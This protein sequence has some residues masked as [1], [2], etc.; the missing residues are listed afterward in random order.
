MKNF[1]ILAL[2]V[3]LSLGLMACSNEDA[4]SDKTESEVIEASE[5]VE[6]SED[7][8]KAEVTEEAE[9][10]EKPSGEETDKEEAEE[11]TGD[12]SEEALNEFEN[13]DMGIEA[14]EAVDRPKLLIF[15]NKGCR[16]CVEMKPYLEALN[17]KYEGQAIIKYIDT[18]ENPGMAGKYPIYGTPAMIIEDKEGKA[19]IPSEDFKDKAYQFA[20]EG[21]SEPSL[22]M[23]YGYM[24]EEEV[25]KL[26]QE[27]L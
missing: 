22:T 24:E 5:N 1:K 10:E 7:T 25:D 21:S 18:D 20:E 14:L 16:Y 13:I 9:E 2:G 6:A 15:G 19:Y 23:L 26:I 3:L 8:E 11:P 17:K 12:V 27:L 4:G